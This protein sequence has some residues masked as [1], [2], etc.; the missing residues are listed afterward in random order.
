MFVFDEGQLSGGVIP[1]ILREA[2]C[3]LRYH[4]VENTP[5]VSQAMPV[6]SWAI[7]R[8]ACR[9]Q[10]V[11]LLSSRSYCELQELPR[12]IWNVLHCAVH[13][14]TAVEYYSATDCMRFGSV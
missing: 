4:T 12:T 8:E 9:T 10:Q 11:Y 6:L 5:T 1:H 13:Q 7:D 3:E 2:C 14:S